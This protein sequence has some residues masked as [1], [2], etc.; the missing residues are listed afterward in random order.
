MIKLNFK[1]YSPGGPTDPQ[2]KSKNFDEELR[3]KLKDRKRRGLTTG[4]SDTAEES[5]SDVSSDDI[6]GGDGKL[7]LCHQIFIKQLSRKYYL[8]NF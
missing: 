6:G 8:A 3:M 4:L 2:G 7:R 5:N 1:L